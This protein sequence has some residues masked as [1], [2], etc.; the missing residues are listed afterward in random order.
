VKKEENIPQIIKK[1]L[2]GESNREELHKAISYFKDPR[3]DQTIENLISETWGKNQFHIPGEY[4]CKDIQ[5]ILERI[6]EKIEPEL[7]EI[8]Q[9]KTRRLF[10]NISRIAAILVIGVFMGILVNTLKKEAPIVY[11]SLTPKGSVSQMILPD[12]TIVYLN[13]D[14]ELKFTY[15][16]LK[17]RREVFLDGEAWFQVSG[18]KKKPFVVHTAWYDVVVTGTEFNVK[19]YKEENDIVT[20]LESGSV[21]IPST[22]KFSMKSSVM[23]A[24]GE[25]LIFNQEK[26]TVTTRKVKT[27]YY[28]SWKENKLI[29]INMSL[30]ELITLLERKYDVDIEVVEGSIL[31][32]HYD[33]TIKNE[34]ILEIMDLIKITLP[35]DYKIVGQKIQITKKT[36]RALK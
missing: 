6:H 21:V 7:H 10:I 26:Q 4:E 27:G 35:I 24:P 33:G 14:T 22:G 15:N 19:A 32:Y 2:T 36:R 9:Q 30:G 16:S 18:N 8:R 17:R 11:T 25:Q 31:D 12:S 23:L 3:Q 34:N 29:F 20:T 28:T 5:T 1:Y 13:S